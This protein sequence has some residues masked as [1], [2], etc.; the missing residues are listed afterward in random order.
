MILPVDPAEADAP[1]LTIWALTESAGYIA[2]KVHDEWLWLHLLRKVGRIEQMMTA[3]APIVESYTVPAP[4]DFQHLRQTRTALLARPARDGVIVGRVGDDW[5][6][7][8][9]NAVSYRVSW[10]QPTLP[11]DSES[12]IMRR[13]GAPRPKVSMRAGCGSS[14]TARRMAAPHRW[15]CARWSGR[16]SDGIG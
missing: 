6:L 9:V 2:D 14:P 3:R 15:G 13:V 16:P 7:R 5:P 12:V 10:P 1:G 4:H 11:S 8:Y